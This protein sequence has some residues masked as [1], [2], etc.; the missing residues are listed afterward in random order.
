MS[1]VEIGRVFERID[2]HIHSENGNEGGN[3]SE[4]TGDSGMCPKRNK[5]YHIRE[6]AFVGFQ[7]NCEDKV[8]GW[9]SMRQEL[10]VECVADLRYLKG[11]R[12]CRRT[13]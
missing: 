2:L 13:T 12:N 8:H 6:L 9:Y 11:V 1:H 3:S 5:G 4:A 10:K 7:K